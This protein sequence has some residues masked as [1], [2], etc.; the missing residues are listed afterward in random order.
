MSKCTIAI[1]ALMVWMASGLLA[2]QR[3]VLF[4][5]YTSITCGPCAAANP[6]VDL[7]LKNAGLGTV[8]VAI[9]YHMNWPSPG[10]DPW[11]WNNVNDNNTRRFYYGVTAVPTG[12]LDGV[13]VGLGQ[14]TLQNAILNRSVI[15]SPYE[16][17]ISADINTNSV[18]VLVKATAAPLAGNNYLRVAVIEKEY[19]TATPFYN[20][21]THCLAPMLQ[22]LPNG[23]G[24]LINIAVG[25]SQSFTFNYN[26]AFFLHPPLGLESLLN[27]VAFVQN[28]QI[29]QVMQAAYAEVGVNSGSTTA[30]ALIANNEVAVVSGYAYN[31]SEGPIN[32][33]IGVSGQI[34]A[35][36]AVTAMSTQGLNIPVNGGTVAFTLPGLSSFYY[37]I[38]LDPQGNTGGASVKA[39][40][41][42]AS[43]PNLVSST[44]YSVSTNDVDILV[45]DD[46]GGATYESYIV[47]E[48]SQTSYM[49]G[50][51]SINS[52]DLTPDE[53]NN[54]NTIIWNCGVAK[55]T[56]TE[57]DR[58]VL[59][60]FLD[61][62]GK[63]YL[64]GV[65]I[66]Y[67]LAD[68]TSPTY[69]G[70]SLAF[71]TNYLHASYVKR[72]HTFLVVKGITG[73]PITGNMT[74]NIGLFGG[75]G[76]STINSQL[77]QYPNQIAAGDFSAA[78]ILYF[79]TRPNEHPAI[80]A[81][82]NGTNGLGGVVF[83]TFGFETIAE[84]SNRTLFAQGVIN[85]LNSITGI[86]DPGDPMVLTRFELKANYPNPFNPSTT[87]AY[88]LPANAGNQV[89]SLVIYNQLGQAVRSLVN[90]PQM[91]GSHTVTWDGRDD[92]GKAVA[93]G[94][95]FYQL[96]YGE[97]R[98]TRKMLLVR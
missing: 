42:L 12:F 31:K 35:G 29:K 55:P 87:I 78:P 39:D 7:A 61:R 98:A 84:A 68:P 82:H 94:V 6:G 30:G 10:T 93:S 81:V 38:I 92:A 20:G 22:M 97:H 49:Y 37:D 13:Q 33:E 48:L 88:D 58:A 2:S 44:L 24:T 56:L 75:S 18:T 50:V 28:D 1:V 67:E 64:N 46:D 5:E 77:G 89:V 74:A 45:V 4:E 36:W 95:Y 23:T 27:V 73:D 14:G 80:R 8:V 63:L 52:G 83:T 86:E 71:F 15:A 19:N 62:G 79:I 51:V 85:W 70:N 69:T 96:R 21:E 32:L 53:L 25:D 60:Q 34:P 16:L 57:E 41:R 47:N 66:A 40:I 17:K 26:P 43:N 3:V 9:K 91:M 54:I 11:Y 65:D 59:S 90:E 76:A 72:Q